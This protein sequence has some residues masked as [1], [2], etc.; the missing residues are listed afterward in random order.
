MIRALYTAASGMNAQQANIDNVAHNLS[1]VNTTGFK[2]SRVEFEDL[3]YQQIKAPGAPTSQE[4][5]AA[6]GLET[7]L[8]TRVVASAR[9]FSVGNLRSTGN[10]LDIAIEGQG[11]F[12]LTL[13]GGETGYTRAGAFHI[14]GQGQI[15]TADGIPLE[16]AIN[17]PQ[18]AMTIT[19]SKDGI[20]SVTTPG[21]EPQQ[22]GTIE[23]ANFQNP[24][25]LQARGGNVFTA[26]IAS[27]DPVT[28]V[29]GAEGMGSL[30]Q[31]MLEDSNVSVVEEM[32]NM[33]LGQRAY[34]ANSKVIRAA[35]EMLQQVNNLPR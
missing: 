14:S 11:F 10:P 1:N 8:G 15:V 6:I 13:P 24:A 3:V 21:A 20:V 30:V 34:E 17:I 7:G 29:P 33:I 12:Q 19:I 18:D 31:A 9:N 16:P 25:G 4:A 5:E 35:D 27:G 26:T 32:V 2:K 28:A 22:V 23:L